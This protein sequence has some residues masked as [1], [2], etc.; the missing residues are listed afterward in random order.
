MFSKC[1]SERR[2]KGKGEK[3]EVKGRTKER[4]EI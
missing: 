1:D 3:E 2:E 4:Q